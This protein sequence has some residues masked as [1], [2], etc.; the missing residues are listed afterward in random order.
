MFAK[1]PWPGK[2]YKISAPTAPQTTANHAV[3]IR[4]LLL[5]PAYRTDAPFAALELDY[6]LE[7]PTFVLGALG[8]GVDADAMAADGQR[9]ARRGAQ[10]CLP[11]S[12]GRNW[13]A[14]ALH[15]S[16]SYMLGARDGGH[17]MRAVIVGVNFDVISGRGGRITFIIADE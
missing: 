17:V 7:H 8:G 9:A 11:I 15:K 14:Q 13:A 6:F 5:L 3:G 10:R 1:Q 16:C 4:W 2:T 12:L